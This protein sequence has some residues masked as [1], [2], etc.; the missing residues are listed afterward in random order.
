MESAG[1]KTTVTMCVLLGELCVFLQLV[2]AFVDFD[3]IMTHVV[4]GYGVVVVVVEGVVVMVHV[5]QQCQ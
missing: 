3:I 5:K 2:V 1:N 4:V